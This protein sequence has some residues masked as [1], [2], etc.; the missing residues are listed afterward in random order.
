M[1]SQPVIQEVAAAED[2][3]RERTPW[4]DTR[5]VDMQWPVTPAVAILDVGLPAGAALDPATAVVTD[6]TDIM[7]TMDTG[8]MHAAATTLGLPLSAA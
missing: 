6:V 7:E 1:L 2:E 5:W 3:Q 4:A 8:T